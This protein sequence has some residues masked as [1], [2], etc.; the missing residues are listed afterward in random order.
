MKI[1]IVSKDPRYALVK[2]HLCRQ[3]SVARVCLPCE[4]D[5]C[6]CLLLSVKK[7]LDISELELIFSRIKKETI[8]LC[9]SD[10]R[11]DK[12]FNGKIINYSKNSDFVVKNAYLTAEATV[13]FLHS[14]TKESFNKKR[15]FI[16]GYGRIGKEL[17]RILKAL[18]SGVFCYARRQETREQMRLDGVNYAP[19][20]RCIECDIVINTVPSVI[21][22]K[23]LIDK[24]PKTTTIIELA[25]LPYGFANMERVILGSGL[26]GKILTSSA[27]DIIFDT[28]CDILSLTKKE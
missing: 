6:D 12:L 5:E 7:E 8:V 17:C 3:G 4:I 20:E 10:E 2:E 21:Y 15:I 23:E 14:I 16:S 18:G 19:I 22:Y 11:I 13:S 26:P 25:S 24:I 1:N 27:A 28:I 9:G